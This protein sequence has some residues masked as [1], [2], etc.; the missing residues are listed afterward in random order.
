VVI[1]LEDGQSARVALSSSFWRSCSELRSATIGRRLLDRGAAPWP[2][3][4]PRGSCLLTSVVTASRHDCL[5]G[6]HCGRGR[7][8]AAWGGSRRLAGTGPLSLGAVL[9]GVLHP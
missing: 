4:S 9:D 5:P 2:R 3:I 8:T 7:T 1:D 6:I